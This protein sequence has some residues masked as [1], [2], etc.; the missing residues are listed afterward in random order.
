MA[1]KIS[2]KRKRLHNLL[3]LVVSIISLQSVFIILLATQWI[4]DYDINLPLHWK[5]RSHLGL[6]RQTFRK[7]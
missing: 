6:T 4:S 5:Q 3:I 1:R 2:Q 7:L